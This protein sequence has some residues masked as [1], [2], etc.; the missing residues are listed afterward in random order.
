MWVMWLFLAL[1]TIKLVLFGFLVLTVLTVY[2]RGLWRR[3]MQQ[4]A[5]LDI[6]RSLSN[7]KF[8]ALLN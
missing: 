8:S 3:K 5:A 7:V 1:G 2:T 6:V 4:N